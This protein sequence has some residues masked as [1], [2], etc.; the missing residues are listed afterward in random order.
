MIVDNV[1]DKLGTTNSSTEKNEKVTLQTNPP[2]LDS[3]KLVIN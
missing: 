1:A 3:T 2:M